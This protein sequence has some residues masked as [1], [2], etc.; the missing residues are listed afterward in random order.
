[1]DRALSLARC[2]LPI[3]TSSCKGEIKIPEILVS[4]YFEFLK[5]L[6]L[7][8]SLSV[9]GGLNFGGLDICL[10]LDVV[11]EMIGFLS[12]ELAVVL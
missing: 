8:L 10:R 7:V 2:F 9:I 5:A 1:M 3:G 4:A 12:L 6:V 11:V